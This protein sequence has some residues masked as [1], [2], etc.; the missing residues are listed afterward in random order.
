MRVFSDAV[1]RDATPEAPW[2]DGTNG[3]LPAARRVA[4]GIGT[5]TV[6]LTVTGLMDAG[7]A[8][9]FWITLACLDITGLMD[10]G[11]AG[12]FGITRAGLDVAGLMDAGGAGAALTSTLPGAL[13]SVEIGSFLAVVGTQGLRSFIG[14]TRPTRPDV[15]TRGPY[16]AQSF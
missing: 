11:G 7:G 1:V 10:A 3:L 6:G 16:R 12:A 8:G 14:V 9:A 2:I 13:L 5:P 4:F 15:F